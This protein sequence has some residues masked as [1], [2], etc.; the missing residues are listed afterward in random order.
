MKSYPKMKKSDL[1]EIGEIP[2]EWKIIRFDRCLDKLESGNRESG[3]G[4]QL[5]NGVPSIGGEHITVEHKIQFSSQKYISEDFFKRMK[6]GKI[7]I[8]DILLV[9]D[10]AT[11]GKTAIYEKNIFE[12][13]AVNEHVFL[14]RTNE[15][16]IPQFTFFYIMSKL[17]QDQ[18]QQNIRGAA[19]GGLNS[20][21]TKNCFL[22][23]PSII[24]QHKIVKF[25]N[26]KFIDFEKKLDENKKLFKLLKEKKQKL[27]NQ[28]I[29]KGLDPS[30]PMK[31]SGI[32]WIGE[33]PEHWVLK[34]LKKII[35]HDTS[36]TYG[37]VQT[38]EH[39]ENGIP[40]IRTSDM[41]GKLFPKTGY[42]KT[43]SE[44]DTKFKRSKVFKND[45]VV[46]I[47]ATVGK[48]MIVPDYLDGANLT[49]GTAKISPNESMDN[50]FV[51]NAIN[52]ES[53]QQ[54]FEAIMKGATFKEITLAMLRNFIITCP[55][56]NEQKEISNF[57]HN[58]IKKIEILISNI[59]SET[60]KIQEYRQVLITSVITGKIDLREVT[61]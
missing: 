49:Q 2:E 1:M 45:I 26:K 28:S 8:N 42:I 40:C 34:E 11:I 51:L 9:K 10:G 44:I 31:D 32:S 53:S 23:L 46:A 18:I 48:A 37:V 55:P 47:R 16:I 54:H 35:Q 4:S 6:F 3:G 61:I 33:I 38:G 43:S 39:I 22:P 5:D 21:F 20:G 57:I 15:M 14:I 30:V 19:Q 41:K 24:E 56:L 17:G 12:N 52:S 36:I 29:T 25:L 59:I 50:E 60:K 27:L 58:E 7:K 13:A